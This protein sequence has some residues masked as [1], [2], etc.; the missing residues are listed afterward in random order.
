MVSYIW[1]RWKFVSYTWQSRKIVSYTYEKDMKM[2][3]VSYVRKKRKL[4]ILCCWLDKVNIPYLRAPIYQMSVRKSVIIIHETLKKLLHLY[5]KD[6]ICYHIVWQSR[7][8]ISKI[9]F[10]L[11][12]WKNTIYHLFCRCC[13]S[14]LRYKPSFYYHIQ[15]LTQRHGSKNSEPVAYF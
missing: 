6:K 15:N 9:K 10:I 14:I 12:I 3:F 2:Q 4:Y 11:Y 13:T 8:F 1:R 5:D 7:K